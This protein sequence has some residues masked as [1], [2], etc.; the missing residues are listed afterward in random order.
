MRLVIPLRPLVGVAQAEVCRQVDHLDAGS[1][2]LA[3]QRVRDA[4][5]SSKE[6]YIAG[7]QCGDIRHGKAQV[8]IVTAQIGIH[9]G[10]TEAFL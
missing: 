6:H 4:V 5:R 8:V 10:N 7:A 9:I 2:Q 3:G 1:Q